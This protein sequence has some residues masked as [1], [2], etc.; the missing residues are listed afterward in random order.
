ME[1]APKMSHLRS[2]RQAPVRPRI[3]WSVV[4]A[5]LTLVTAS[6]ASALVIHLDGAPK[7]RTVEVLVQFKKSVIP[8]FGRATI[9]ANR[10]RPGVALPIINGMS[11]RMSAAAAARLG[12]DPR[13]RAVTINRRVGAT[14]G[15]DLSHLATVFNQSVNA[16]DV[17]PRATGKGVGVAVIDTGIAGD[18]PDFATSQTDP[19]SRVVASVVTNPAA[20]TAGDGYGHGTYVAGIIAG[21]GWARQKPDSLYG[22]YVGVA[23]DANLISVKVADEQGNSTVL[24]VLMGLSFVIQHKDDL[25]IRVVNM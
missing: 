3:R 9:R 16:D 23:P 6:P 22:K 18:L 15:P 25:N 17:W 19:T 1:V 14:G 12:H 20:K 10:G 11:A 5:F 7:A 2:P 4:A 21:N 8:A 13:V 24:D